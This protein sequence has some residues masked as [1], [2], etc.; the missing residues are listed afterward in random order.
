MEEKKVT[1]QTIMNF[2]KEQIEQKIPIA[3]SIWLDGASKANI[4]MEN[5]DDQLGEAEFIVS[6]TI[7]KE[8][9]SGSSVALAKA[10][11]NAT[12]AYK[13]LQKLKAD[14]ARAVEFMR[15]AKKRVELASNH[16]WDS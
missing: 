9:D 13:R 16:K 6:E 11:A 7:A 14:K 2:F 4:L 12:E 15:L 10:K 1:I 8:I 5:L 3:P